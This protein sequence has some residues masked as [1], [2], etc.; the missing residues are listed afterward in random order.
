MSE[1]NIF[2]QSTNEDQAPDNQQPSF[3]LPTEVVEFVGQ[4]KKYQSVEDALKS[5][6]HAQKH[7]QSLEAELADLKEEVVRRRTTEELLDEIKSGIL[8]NEA[9]TQQVGLD[10]EE[11]ANVVNRTIE[12]REAQQRAKSNTQSVADKFKEKFGDNA[13]TAYETLAKDSGLTIQQLNT[14]TATSP[15]AVLKLANLASQQSNVVSK[16]SSSINTEAL[17]NTSNNS[18]LSAKVPKGAT[19]RDLVNAW[20]IAG[21]KIKTNLTT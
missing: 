2:D 16:T 3:S 20:K 8:P 18:N 15:N 9:T 7:I 21:E 10:K 11:L 5:V 12:F 1:E 17:G 14:L 6:P 4:G 19:T 13:Q